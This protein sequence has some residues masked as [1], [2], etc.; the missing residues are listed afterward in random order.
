MTYSCRIY[1]MPDIVRKMNRTIITR[2]QLSY[3]ILSDPLYFIHHPDFIHHPEERLLSILL[4]K[5]NLRRIPRI[6]LN[7]VSDKSNH[8]KVQVR[9]P[10]IFTDEEIKEYESLLNIGNDSIEKQVEYLQY[11]ERCEKE[12]RE[13]Q[14]NSH[15]NVM[16]ST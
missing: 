16:G 8:P 12:W 5:R 6:K 4:E 9:T 13:Y 3:D 2:Q 15:V 10:H 14:K 1:P 7:P 11:M